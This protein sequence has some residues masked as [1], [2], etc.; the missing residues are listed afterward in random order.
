M[1]GQVLLMILT[2][3]RMENLPRRPSNGAVSC[4]GRDVQIPR[5]SFSQRSEFYSSTS[6][7]NTRDY[8]LYGQPTEWLNTNIVQ[9]VILVVSIFLREFNC[10]H[11]NHSM[12][13]HLQ[14][15]M[16]FFF[17][18]SRSK[19][20]RNKAHGRAHPY[21]P[22]N[23]CEEDEGLVAASWSWR[24]TSR[25]PAQTLGERGWCTSA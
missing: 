1:R 12:F 7:K 9:H 24:S 3:H 20:S 2:L 5:M 14:F 4:V 10:P 8:R 18:I 15:L 25:A 22:P 6:P 21:A 13:C 16:L 23:S 17:N 19:I 11:F